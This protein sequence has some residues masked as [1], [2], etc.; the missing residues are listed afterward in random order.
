MHYTFLL[1]V[2][3]L[4]YFQKN[5]YILCGFSQTKHIFLYADGNYSE[6]I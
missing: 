1:H 3:V 2:D 4:V 6:Y 5:T